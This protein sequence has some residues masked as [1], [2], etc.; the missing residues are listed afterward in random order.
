MEKNYNWI[1]ENQTISFNITSCIDSESGVTYNWTVNDILGSQENNFTLNGSV[2]GPGIYNV[3]GYCI[4]DRNATDSV[5]FNLEIVHQDDFF[6][7]VLPDTQYYS[8]DYPYIFSNQTSWVKDM[9]DNMN[10][11]FLVHEGDMVHVAATTAQ[12]INANTSMSILDGYV[13]YAVT[14]GNHD[15]NNLT[16][17]DTTNYNNYFPIGRYNTTS[18]WG[19]SYSPT[20][21]VNT[22]QLFEFAGEKYLILNL[23]FCPNDAVLAWANTTLENY[24]DRNAIMITHGYMQYN[25]TRLHDG[26]GGDCS[27]YGITDGN[28]GEEQWE[29]FV[30]WHDNLKIVLSGHIT[31]ITDVFGYLNSTN[32]GGKE[33]FQMLADYQTYSYGGSGYLRLLRFSPS[34][35]KVYVQSYSPWLDTMWIDEANY[36]NFSYEFVEEDTSYPQFNNVVFNITNN[37]EYNSLTY[38]ANATITNTNGTSGLEFNGINY[39]STNLSSVFSSELSELAAGSYPYYWWS[40][41]NGTNNNF[42][43]SETNQYIVLINSSLVLGISGSTPIA[44]GTTTD[45]AGSNC[46]SQLTCSLDKSNAVYGAG[47]E[48]FN[49]STAGNSNYSA[50]YIT[51]DI[52]IN[53]AASEVNLTLNDS[54][55]N[56]TITQGNTILLNGTLVTGDSSATLELYNNGTLSNS[57]SLEVSNLTTFNTVGLF[58]I[59]VYYISS[60]NYTMSSETYWVNVTQAPDT[61][62]P[63]FSNYLDNNATLNDSGTGWFNVTIENTNGTVWLNINNTNYTATNL[64]SNIYNVS[65]D[66]DSSGTYNYT[67]YAY[68]NGSTNLLNNSQLRYY[69]INETT[70]VITPETPVETPITSRGGGGSYILEQNTKEG[71]K[72]RTLLSSNRTATTKI[73]QDKGTG[74]K[75]IELKSKNWFS[76]EIFV[77]AYNETP[78]FCS[79]EYKDDHKVYK[80]LDFNTTIKDESIDSGRLKIGISKEWIYDNNISEIKFVKCYPEYFIVTSSYENETEDEG[81]YNIYISGFSAYAILGTMESSKIENIETPKDNTTERIDMEKILLILCSVIILIIVFILVV[82]HRILL[83]EKIHSKFFDFEFKFRVGKK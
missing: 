56:I 61:T 19:G 75:E 66:L 18:Y 51:K 41:G 35:G 67:W 9:Q 7:A 29:K 47:N 38:L 45:V 50:T 33:V 17:K 6:M 81:I 76:G 2:Y 78:D 48:T 13:N 34:E 42:N 31:S 36:F 65:V 8:R 82:K 60:Q 4:D 57:S 52:I 68:G 21:N 15:Y 20:S 32:V 24:T 5:S 43:S 83:K 22:Y 27:D 28:T 49:Y 74:I 44:Y 1:L 59:T 55:D 30:K 40:Y 39:S 69:L 54:E 64:T 37:S 77:V 53:Q 16:T 58:N 11:Q 23:G 62:Y 12:W 79:I 14:P 71:L 73:K 80:V 26:D 63:Q 10:I 70:P 3:T 25:L 72:I 46:P